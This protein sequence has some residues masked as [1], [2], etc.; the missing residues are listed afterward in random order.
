[1]KTAITILTI[2]LFSSIIYGQNAPFANFTPSASSYIDY[3]RGL[4]LSC[5]NDLSLNNKLTITMWVKWANKTDPG[6]GNWANLFTLADSTNSGDNGVFW[7]QHNSDNSRFEFA[8]HS[9]SRDYIYSTTNPVNETWYFLTLV[10]D[11]S[12]ANNNM[13]IFVNGV[14]E[15]SLNKT[16]NIRVFPTAS[17]LNMGRWSNPSNNYRHFN[18]KLDEVSI[19]KIA[20]TSTQISNMMNNPTSITGI[21]HD[22][23]GLIGY[24]DF[25]NNTA[26]NLG[27]CAINGV[28]G[29][30]ASL[31]VTFTSLMATPENGKVNVNWTTATE[32]NN[33]YFLVQ[34]SNNGVDFFDAGKIVG[35]GNSNVTNY[36]NFTDYN[37]YSGTSYYRLRQVDFDGK[38]S[39]SSI[40]NVTF[41]N[42]SNFSLSL[43]PNPSNGNNVNAESNFDE[44]TYFDIIVTDISGREIYRSKNNI[45]KANIPTTEFQKGIFFIKA[46]SG[47]N[48][49]TMK[50][51]ND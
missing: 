30:G 49:V 10:Y 19:W 5:L 33:D 42:N 4:N 14:Q 39:Y 44:T 29:S 6:V 41:N 11:G 17:R 34:K 48:T 21:N 32:I 45:S 16:G 50:L 20:L 15:G 3:G 37:P 18:G 25:N 24:W 31:P 7:V 9:N 13:K 2:I 47:E 28:M 8:L 23:T 40:T 1:M 35:V 43:F 22:A 38:E 26:N 12:L 51:I 27:A 46:I 36:Y